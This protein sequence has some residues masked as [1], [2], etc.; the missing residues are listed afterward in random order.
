M[1]ID[2]IPVAVADPSPAPSAN[3]AGG[4]GR[5]FGRFLDT[6]DAAA[7]DRA[8]PRTASA[9]E[10]TTERTAP[11]RQTA[12]N[13][14]TD[15]ARDDGRG[16]SQA[17]KPADSSPVGASQSTQSTPT[18]GQ[19]SDTPPAAKSKSAGRSTSF[20]GGGRGDKAAD[21]GDP[22]TDDSTAQCATV[23][24]PTVAATPLGF[25]PLLAPVAAVGDTAAA[26]TSAMLG[27]TGKTAIAAL[28]AASAKVAASGQTSAIGSGTKSQSG[29]A[30]ATDAASPAAIGAAA[31]SDAT[32]AGQASGFPAT[33]KSAASDLA[34]PT[35]TAPL[36]ATA[37]P[38]DTT[39][40]GSP[41]PTTVPAGNRGNKPPISAQAAALLGR[42]SV[43]GAAQGS[44]PPAA[45]IAATGAARA[46]IADAAANNAAGKTVASPATGPATGAAAPAPAT[47]KGSDTAQPT[48]LPPVSA[49][50]DLTTKLSAAVIPPHGDAATAAAAKAKSDSHATAA[51]AETGSA[52][53]AAGASTDGAAPGAAKATAAA[54]PAAAPAGLAGPAED[55]GVGG[56]TVDTAATAAQPRAD[57][58]GTTV[59]T[60]SALSPARETA[61]TPIAA[62][63]SVAEQV[64]VALKRGVKSG[65]DQIQIN[66]E[67]A[68]LGKIAVR[69][70]F[71]QDGHVSAT[72]SADRP[73]TLTLLNNDSRHLEQALR[74][75]GLRTDS[76]SLTFNLSSG[77]NGAGA[78][79][80]AQSANYA[81]NAASMDD[82][83]SLLPL[84]AVSAAPTRL[85]RHDGSLDIHV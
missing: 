47:G 84:A 23:A 18:T 2:P 63:H 44:T 83:S 74:D 58:A 50:V 42:V 32:P 80:F 20:S 21:S 36:P 53:S 54:P 79:Q 77:D 40:S 57:I 37:A 28:V 68:S 19:S 16:R 1:H 76:G 9:M 3:P 22:A 34:A 25:V 11:A 39:A 6:A 12:R 75:A 5:S 64:A 82:G 33:V 8:S 72:F 70:D 66:L 26:P 51:A 73:D 43:M 38:S 4:G 10:T 61:P 78:R 65:N 31:G 35:G 48:P 14:S 49:A 62:L 30:P 13:A 24:V 81:A 29:Q 41:A 60:A 71:A 59:N 56:H 85:S 52:K 15:K 67:P 45:G 27:K 7:N 17:T 46:Q 69:L 55:D